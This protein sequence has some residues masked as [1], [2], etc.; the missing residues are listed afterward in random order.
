M[1]VWHGLESRFRYR[2][3]LFGEIKNLVIWLFLR[4]K[5]I[6]PDIF[7]IRKMGYFFTLFDFYYST[8]NLEYKYLLYVYMSKNK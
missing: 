3:F 4:E 5:K 7:Q 8:N 1:L 2:H 6:K